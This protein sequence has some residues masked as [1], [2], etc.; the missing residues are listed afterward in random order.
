[1]YSVFDAESKKTFT[2]A[3]KK[4]EVENFPHF[5]KDVFFVFFDQKE[6]IAKGKN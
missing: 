3:Y 2:E 4:N 5:K 1:L 6:A